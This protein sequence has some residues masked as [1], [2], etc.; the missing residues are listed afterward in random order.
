MKKI[1]SIFVVAILL[2]CLSLTVF[3][4]KK[5]DAATTTTEVTTDASSDAS[6]DAV[7]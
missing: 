5:K 3:S 2:I 6:T 1:L 4:C 7:Q